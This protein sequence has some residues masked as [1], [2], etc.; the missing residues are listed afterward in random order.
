MWSV[1]SPAPGLAPIVGL[2]VQAHDIAFGSVGAG[3]VSVPACMVDV[4]HVMVGSG[5]PNSEAVWQIVLR[6]NERHVEIPVTRAYQTAPA[7]PR[8][9]DGFL[10]L[11]PLRTRPLRLHTPQTHTSQAPPCRWGRP[12]LYP[13]RTYSAWYSP[14]IL[15]WTIG[16]AAHFI[17]TEVASRR[18][19]ALGLEL[20][21]TPSNL[22]SG[23][24]A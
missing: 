16:S 17:E 1:H 4:L 15:H 21:S 18:C 23:P 24:S 11:A 12:C 2:G 10:I 9:V 14:G 3:Q 5:E 22:P 8:I 20:T 6:S 7:F 13:T 19:S